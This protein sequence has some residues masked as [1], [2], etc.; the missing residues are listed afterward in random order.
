MKIRTKINETEYRKQWRKSINQ[1]I[2]IYKIHTNDKPLVRLTK[3]KRDSTQIINIRNEIG[4]ITTDP[5]PM[6]K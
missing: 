4:A 5:P 3:T 2:Y 6:R 1:I